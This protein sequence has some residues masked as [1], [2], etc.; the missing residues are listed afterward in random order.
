MLK[1][2]TVLFEASAI[3]SHSYI[4]KTN[5]PCETFGLSI[6]LHVMQVELEYMHTSKNSTSAYIVAWLRI[7]QKTAQKTVNK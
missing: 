7:E 1:T 4:N 5:I 6:V 2:C 3:C